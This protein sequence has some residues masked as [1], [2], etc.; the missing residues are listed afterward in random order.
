M[1]PDNDFFEAACTWV[2]D[3][4]RA[5]VRLGGFGDIEDIEE[6]ELIAA[7]NGP[8][9]YLT[10]P[11]ARLDALFRCRR[12]LRPGGVLFVDVFNLP[13]Y[14]YHYR[15]PQE[16]QAEVGGQAVRRLPRQEI[17]WH[18][19]VLIHK[20]VFTIADE[21]GNIIRLEKTHTLAILTVPEILFMLGQA[22]FVDIRTYNSYGSRQSEAIAGGRIM[23][24]AQRGQQG[25]LSQ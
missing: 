22:G 11:Q 13:W 25:L 19:G 3:N 21:H 20:E 15:L 18:A 5:T 14:F 9:Y 16:W 8:F 7:V 12:A 6:F 24:S 2:D 10:T 23:I 1:E 4:G 17:D